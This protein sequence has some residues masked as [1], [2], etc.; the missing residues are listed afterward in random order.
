MKCTPQCNRIDQNLNLTCLRWSTDDAEDY[1]LKQS[2]ALVG[3]TLPIVFILLQIML[4]KEMVY[5]DRYGGLLG[6]SSPESDLSTSDFYNS[7]LICTGS[8]VHLV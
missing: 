2:N 5:R 6:V 7:R 8:N 4:F 3:S 1:T